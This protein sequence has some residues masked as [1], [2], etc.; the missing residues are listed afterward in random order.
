MIDTVE[1]I[2]KIR[3]ILDQLLVK[4]RK[5]EE[6]TRGGIWIPKTA[7]NQEPVYRGTVIAVGPGRYLDDGR[8]VEPSVKK[9]DEV[10]FG[11]YSAGREIEVGDR[12]YVFIHE[13]DLLSTLEA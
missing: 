2:G 4:L 13:G 11:K 5:D 1:E 10:V 3:P 7:V 9:G 6:K 12:K 8:R